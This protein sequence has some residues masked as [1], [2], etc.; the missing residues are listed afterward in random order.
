MV[1]LGIDGSRIDVSVSENVTH[2][3]KR[4]PLAKHLCGC[5]VPKRMR[6]ASAHAGCTHCAHRQARDRP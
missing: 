1:N 4:R 6:T 2:L 3:S 5:S